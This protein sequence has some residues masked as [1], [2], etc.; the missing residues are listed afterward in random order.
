MTSKH[1]IVPSGF[2]HRGSFPNYFED[3]LPRC[4]QVEAEVKRNDGAQRLLHFKSCQTLQPEKGRRQN[5]ER[6]EKMENLE[7]VPAAPALPRVVS[8]T[9]LTHISLQFLHNDSQR[10]TVSGPA[11]PRLLSV[12]LPRHFL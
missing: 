10:A 4:V 8:D 2:A 1:V 7:E 3:F 11:G 6:N 5:G 9:R 12:W